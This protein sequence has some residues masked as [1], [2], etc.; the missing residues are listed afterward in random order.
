M[1]TTTL[2]TQSC[3]AVD[4]LVLQAE[5]QIAFCNMVEAHRARLYRFILKNVKHPDDAADLAQQAFV[6][7]FRSL[8]SFRGESEL[9]TWLYGIALNLV[10]GHLMRSPQRNHHFE[11]EEILVEMSGHELD[12]NVQASLTETVSAVQ[13]HF[14]ALP[15]EMRT[16]LE[17]VAIDEMSY[18]EVA[19]E[20][21][22]PVGTVRSRVFRARAQLKN[23]LG[24]SGVE[25]F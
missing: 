13:T 2:P 15:I 7:A 21:N 4:T 19:K 1:N 6:E 24:A 5:R 11:S 12:P 3:D 16:V 17:M 9:S 23:A 25:A 8:Q 22:I 18:E 14:N 20:L 10:R